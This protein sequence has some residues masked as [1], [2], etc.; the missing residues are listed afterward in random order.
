MDRLIELRKQ[1]D[2]ID[3]K[4]IK[5]IEKRFEISRE[6]GKLKRENGFEIEDKKREKEIIENRI[7]NSKLSKEFTMNLFNLIFKESKIMQE[8]AR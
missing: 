4:I 2:N 6:I 1:I 8:T 5:L 3:S 7:S